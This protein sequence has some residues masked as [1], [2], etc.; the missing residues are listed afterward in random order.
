M[1][2]YDKMRCFLM[3]EYGLI[4]ELA[5]ICIFQW[6]SVLVLRIYR[7]AHFVCLSILTQSVEFMELSSNEQMI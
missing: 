1:V 7:S 6:F 5:L 2:M 4:E 3:G